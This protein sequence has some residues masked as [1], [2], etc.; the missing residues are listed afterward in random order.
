MAIPLQTT[1]KDMAASP[2]LEARIRE[3]A[4]RLMRLED[5][6]RLTAAA[7]EKGLQA[8]TVHP[9]GQHRLAP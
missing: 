8:S 4:E 3:K 1:V 9:S 5:A 6:V 2:A 7:G